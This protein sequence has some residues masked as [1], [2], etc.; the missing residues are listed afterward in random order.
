[1]EPRT[2]QGALTAAVLVLLL[3]GCPAPSPVDDDANDL[4]ARTQAAAV[5]GCQFEPAANSIIQILAGN[6]AGGCGSAHARSDKHPKS[7]HE[8]HA[9]MVLQQRPSCPIAEELH[10]QVEQVPDT[11]LSAVEAE[12]KKTEVSL[13]WLQSIVFVAELARSE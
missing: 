4:V 5:A 2:L 12:V 6:V 3:A 9:S 1:M 8:P 11:S 7:L 13:P 10:H